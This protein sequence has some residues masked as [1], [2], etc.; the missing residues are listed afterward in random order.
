MDEITLIQA[1]LARDV[2]NFIF[3]P[4]LAASKFIAY[5]NIQIHAKKSFYHKDIIFK[6]S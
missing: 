5:P 2:K 6:W 3:L 4:F 1:G